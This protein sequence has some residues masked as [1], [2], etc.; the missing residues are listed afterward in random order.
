MNTV[1]HTYGYH[2]MTAHICIQRGTH[3]HMNG[4]DAHEHTVRLI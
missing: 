4:V 2:I 1:W 3:W